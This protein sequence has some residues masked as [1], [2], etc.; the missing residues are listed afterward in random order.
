MS[1]YW[2]WIAAAAGAAVVALTAN[3]A[4][5]WV[6]C[7]REGYCWHTHHRYGYRDESGVVIHPNGWRW[8]PGEHYVWHEHHGR[9]YWRNGVWIRY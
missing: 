8:G 3:S 6:A 4:S 7:N 2:K 1:R 9:G 5:A